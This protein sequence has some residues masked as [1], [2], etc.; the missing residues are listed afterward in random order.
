MT[1]LTFKR[2]RI[3][4]LGAFLILGFMGCSR[5]EEGTYQGRIGSKNKVTVRVYPEG[6]IEVEGY[7]RDKLAGSRERGTFRGRDVDALVFEGPEDRRFK[8]R[9][10]YEEEDGGLIILSIQSRTFGP[11]ARYLPTEEDSVFDPPPRL[12]RLPMGAN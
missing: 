6:I 3:F 11:G 12:I 4:S 1:S 10:L 2:F 9:F 7:W 5:L 8:L